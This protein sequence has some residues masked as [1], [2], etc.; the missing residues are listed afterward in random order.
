M[1]EINAF[2]RGSTIRCTMT[3]DSA[4]TDT[5]V[6]F[7]YL[8]PGSSEAVTVTYDGGVSDVQKVS[9]TKF[10][11][12]IQT[13]TDGLWAVQAKGAKGTVVT[14]EEKEFEIRKSKF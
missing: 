11:L 4:P 5:T 9:A 7:K 1:A 10:I 6:E 14:V 12:D 2:D 13:A 8:A 3:F